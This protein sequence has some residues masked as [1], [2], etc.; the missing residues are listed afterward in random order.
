MVQ[1]RPDANAPAPS[2]LLA[3]PLPADKSVFEQAVGE[4]MRAVVES[5]AEVEQWSGENL[6]GHGSGVF[7]TADGYVLTAAHVVADAHLRLVVVL[8]SGQSR[9]AGVVTVDETHDIAILHAPGGAV[10]FARLAG[11]S[12]PRAGEWIVC[13]G[14]GGQAP[15]DEQPMRS[16]GVV[17]SSHYNWPVHK[18]PPGGLRAAPPTTT[19]HPDMLLL[20]CPI[21]SG[22]SGGPV[23]SLDGALVGVVVAGGHDG[24]AIAS[25]I[26]FARSHLP[27]GVA[28]AIAPGALSPERPCPEC[29]DPGSD[30]G[31]EQALRPLVATLTG[32]KLER[33]LVELRVGTAPPFQ[34]VLVSADLAVTPAVRVTKAQEDGRAD[35][36][37]AAGLTVVGHPESAAELVALREGVALLRL[38]GLDAAARPIGQASAAFVGEIVVAIDRTTP[39]GSAGFVTAIDRHP[40]AIEPIAP[41]SRHGSC[42][43][44]NAAI[45]RSFREQNPSVTVGAALATDLVWPRPGAVLVDREGHPAALELGSRAPGLSFA[46]PWAEVVGRFEPWLAPSAGASGR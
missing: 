45:Q 8:S 7:V 26:N 5:M 9:G 25:S 14:Y 43:T 30:P 11:S 21:T 31:R 37:E 6:V 46:V 10:P 12:P 17:S 18:Y 33:S 44:H 15:G 39:T 41:P 35:G 40:G 36:T 22:M 27:R 20:D 13:A 29:G 38:R 42:G 24:S 23:V 34:A 1:E 3:P 32:G 19:L 4:R 2:P 16:A 28:P